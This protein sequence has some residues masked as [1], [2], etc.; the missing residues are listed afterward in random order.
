MQL[1]TEPAHHQRSLFAPRC[2]SKSISISRVI[3]H[4]HAV[5]PDVHYPAAQTRRCGMMRRDSKSNAPLNPPHPHPSSKLSALSARLRH[6]S[7]QVLRPQLHCIKS[8]C[9]EPARL[10]GGGGG[11]AASERP[12]S[13]PS[14]IKT[15]R[16]RVEMNR[17]RRGRKRGDKNWQRGD[18][19][20]LQCL[21]GEGGQGSDCERGPR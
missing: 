5:S 15:C 6:E 4:V 21:G 20:G 19:S 3:W 14:L 12:Q 9:S 7:E 2:S 11:D 8:G 13:H 10:G 1:K 16:R 17:S 18:N